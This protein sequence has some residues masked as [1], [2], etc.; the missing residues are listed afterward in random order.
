[1]CIY[2]YI[3]IYTHLEGGG[4][5]PARAA[6]RAR[7]LGLLAELPGAGDAGRPARGPRMLDNNAY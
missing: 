7:A 4:R 2:I 3:Y 1:M 5:G 6:R